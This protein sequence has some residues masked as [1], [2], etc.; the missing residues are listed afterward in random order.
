VK[1]GIEKTVKEWMMHLEGEKNHLENV[2]TYGVIQQY[3]QHKCHGFA[4]KVF[5]DLPGEV[6]KDVPETNVK[7]SNKRRVK[8]TTKSGAENVLTVSQLSTLSGYPVIGING[9]QTCVHIMCF[10]AFFP[11]EY[12]AMKPDE[13]VRHKNDDPLDFC[14]ENLLIGTRTQNMLDAY[15]NGKRDGTKSARKPC[16]SYINGVEEPEH[17]SIAYAVRYLKEH[18]Y[19]NAVSSGIRAALKNNTI[20]YDRTWKLII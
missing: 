14:P 15:D 18:G 5:E 20:R 7:I 13:I 12:K 11:D 19:P 16:L 1:D 9:K 8:R 2:Y 4:Y 10:Q 6:W 17:T 3:A